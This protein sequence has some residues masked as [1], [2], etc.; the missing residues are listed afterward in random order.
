MINFHIF[1]QELKLK[2]DSY[3]LYNIM[4]L[5]EESESK[6]SIIFCGFFCICFLRNIQPISTKN[7]SY[8]CTS[9]YTGWINQAYWNWSRK[10]AYI[11]LLLPSTS[12]PNQPEAL[13][14]SHTTSKRCKCINQMILRMKNH[15]EDNCHPYVKHVSNKYKIMWFLQKL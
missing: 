2:T 4:S 8:S 7:G 1:K 11:L 14:R 10:K 3:T 6:V 12:K 15:P 13:L 9:R 5:N